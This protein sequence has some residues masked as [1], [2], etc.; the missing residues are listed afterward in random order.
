MV[1]GPL[2]SKVPNFS[3]HWD[4]L[5]LVLLLGHNSEFSFRYGIPLGQNAFRRFSF[6]CYYKKLHAHYRKKKAFSYGKPD[7]PSISAVYMWVKYVY[8]WYMYRLCRLDMCMIIYDG[9][10]GGAS[11]KEPTCKC[12]RHKRCGSERSHREGHGNPL[13]YSCLENPMDW[14]DWRATIHR[15]TK[16][17]MWLKQ[18]SM[19]YTHICICKIDS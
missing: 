9:L 7:T 10:P 4:I 12:R 14:G 2:A 3:N 13:L 5:S 19:W 17:Q 16:S 11:G 15:V 18:L 6:F 8:S 1:K